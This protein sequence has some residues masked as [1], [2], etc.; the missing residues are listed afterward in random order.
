[1]MSRF[2]P[3]ER[4]WPTIIV[5]VL[6][7]NVVLGIVLSR[8]ASGGSSLATEPDYYRKAVLWDSTLAQARRD[9]ALGWQVTPSL[10]ALGPGV[11]AARNGAGDVQGDASRSASAAGPGAATGA[12]LS[13]DVR[14]AAGVPVR[15][16]AVRVDAWQL[17]HGDEALAAT[18]APDA[19]E[20]Y[21]AWLPMARAGRWEV[22]VEATR[23]SDRFTATLR[24]DASRSAAG[25]EV[26]E[27]PGD[28]SAA[29]LAAGTRR[30]RGTP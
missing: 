22:R 26:G 23:G 14:D 1:M 15:G 19:A 17:A 11:G 3:K 20:G 24:M 13:L 4:I 8:I 7:A 28:A 27:R 18:L 5:T 16:A 12:V 10:S 21:R 6:T 30:E 29:R 25:R 9:A 2:M